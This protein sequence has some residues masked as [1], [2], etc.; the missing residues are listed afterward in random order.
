MKQFGLLGSSDS[1]LYIEDT[2]DSDG[3]LELSI[4][5]SH[6]DDELESSTYL[7]KQA[8]I[9]LIKHLEDVFELRGR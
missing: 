4:T 5:I 9:N 7:D 3:D 6:Y 2:L 1:L 8:A